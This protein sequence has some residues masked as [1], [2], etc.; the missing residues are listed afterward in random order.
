MFNKDEN[1]RLR[2]LFTEWNGGK[3][4]SCSPIRLH[5]HSTLPVIIFDAKDDFI[6]STKGT[7][8]QRN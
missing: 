5:F 4:D 6:I 7:N 8:Q 2:Y 3:D 1:K